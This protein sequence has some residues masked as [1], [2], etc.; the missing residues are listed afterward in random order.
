MIEQI[1]IAVCGCVSVW[2]SQDTRGEWRRY[3]CV[4]GIVAQPFWL[5]ATWKAEQ[6]G[7]FALTFVYAAAW[8]RGIW[9]YW[10][11]PFLLSKVL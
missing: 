7:I 2:L 11:Q 9:N 10:L 4:V 6:W 3:A 5:Y 8:L 1:V